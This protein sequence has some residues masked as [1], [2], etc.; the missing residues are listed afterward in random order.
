[1]SQEQKRMF[2]KTVE[3]PQ[4]IVPQEHRGAVTAERN[5][6]HNSQIWHHLCNV[7]LCQEFVSQNTEQDLF[8]MV[9]LDS[10]ERHRE[11]LVHEEV[12]QT[13]TGCGILGR[14][15]VLSVLAF[16]ITGIAVGIGFTYWQPQDESE[17][18]TK[19]NVLKWL[20]LIGST[21]F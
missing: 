17:A 16:A 21:L 3:Y 11:E 2:L 5:R 15:P 9:V 10:E 18:E 20:G 14:Y 12:N 7:I 1:M 4:L 6:S 8:I 19:A 13:P